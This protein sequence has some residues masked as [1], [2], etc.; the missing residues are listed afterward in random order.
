MSFCRKAIVAGAV[1]LLLFPSGQLLAQQGPPEKQAAQEKNRAGDTSQKRGGRH[2]GKRGRGSRRVNRL[3]RQL[4]EMSSEDRKQF[5][6]SDAS[7]Q[8]LSPR[9]QERIHQRLEE[10]ESL[11]PERQQAIRRRFARSRGDRGREMFLRVAQLPPEEQQKILE[12]DEKFQT[13]SQRS[14]QRFQ[15]QLKRFNQLSPEERYRH[16]QRRQQFESMSPRQR[17]AMRH[18]Q[19]VFADLTPEQREKA[20]KVFRAWRKLPEERRRL[21]Q[22]RLRRLHNAAP[23]ARRAL[24]QDPEFLEP[25]RDQEREILRALFQLRRALPPPERAGQGFGRL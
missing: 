14:Q 3:M 21:I 20:R 6:E 23:V 22:V 1:A 2:R 18:R 5:L 16:L 25:L 15:E 7:F 17:E 12:S 11:P 24:L 4:L 9:T 19:R 8:R 13:Q 10:F